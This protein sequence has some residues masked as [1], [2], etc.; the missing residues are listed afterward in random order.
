MRATVHRAAALFGLVLLVG[1][2][3]TASA[4][5]ATTTATVTWDGNNGSSLIIPTNVTINSGDTVEI[6]FGSSSSFGPVLDI[7][8]SCGSSSIAELAPG[9]SAFVAPSTTTSY[10]LQ[11]KNTGVFSSAVS[12]CV[13][14][15][16][17][18]NG[19]T[20]T[21][22]TPGTPPPD[23]PESAYAVALPIG[24]ALVLGLGIFVTRRRNRARV[25]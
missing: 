13:F 16:V 22:T 3:G 25:A 8:A 9:G 2:L 18:V 14:L 17:N 1:A 15:V 11:A 12:A 7:G 4:N 21:T 20:T 6:T 10:A 19:S 24:A 23:V 5:A